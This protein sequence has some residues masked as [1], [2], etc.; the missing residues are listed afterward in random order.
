MQTV[1]VLPVFPNEVNIMAQGLMQRQVPPLPR[2]PFLGNLNTQVVESV[3]REAADVVVHKDSP[4]QPG[5]KAIEVCVLELISVSH[6]E[7]F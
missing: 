5:P 6:Q 3:D 4:S 2:H 1:S 7:G